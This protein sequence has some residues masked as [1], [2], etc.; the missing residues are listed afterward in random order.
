MRVSFP[1]DEK[2]SGAMMGTVAQHVNVLKATE[3]CTLKV[4]FM[5]CEFCH[6]KKKF[7]KEES[8]FHKN[9]K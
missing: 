6:N 5:L 2:C 3:L 8:A 7:L 9:M 1:G 4:S